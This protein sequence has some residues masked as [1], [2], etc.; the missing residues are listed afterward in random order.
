MNEE[1]IEKA[2]DIFNDESE[3]IVSDLVDLLFEK[4]GDIV[5]NIASELDIDR[6]VVSEELF[7]DFN[8]HFSIS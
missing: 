8:D 2:W 1:Q 6:S 4:L 7:E 3:W 5:D